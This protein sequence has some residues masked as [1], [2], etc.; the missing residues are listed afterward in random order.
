[1]EQVLLELLEMPVLPVRAI[2]EILVLAVVEE[3]EVGVLV[4]MRVLEEEV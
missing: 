1:M 3:V 4:E 2:P